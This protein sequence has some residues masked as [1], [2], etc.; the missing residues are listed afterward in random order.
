MRFVDFSSCTDRRFTVSV[1]KR[2]APSPSLIPRTALLEDTPKRSTI[3][4]LL[5]EGIRVQGVSGPL[6]SSSYRTRALLQ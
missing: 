3:S 4:I 5:L 2:A 1:S 6:L